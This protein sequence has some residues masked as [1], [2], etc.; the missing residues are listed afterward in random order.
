MRS[1]PVSSLFIVATVNVRGLN[2]DKLALLSDAPQKRIDFVCLQE[3]MISNDQSQKV[4]A[5]KWS[6]P[7]FCSPAI[8]QRGGVTILCSPE[9]RDNVSVRQK[10]ADG[11]LSLLVSCNDIRLNLVNVYA[12]TNPTERDVFS[13]FRSLFLSK[14]VSFSGW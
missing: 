2:S 12:P 5:Q 13:I 6:G 11:R 8:G 9:Q 4:L 3:T 14:F 10:D 7:S 1:A